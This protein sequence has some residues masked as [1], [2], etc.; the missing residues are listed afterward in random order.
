[1]TPRFNSTYYYSFENSPTPQAVYEEKNHTLKLHLSFANYNAKEFEVNNSLFELRNECD[2]I[3]SL[4]TNLDSLNFT[5][6][7]FN[8][9][10]TLLNPDIETTLISP[11]HDFLMSAHKK[12]VE[13]FLPTASQNDELPKPRITP[14]QNELLF[15]SGFKFDQK[16]NLKML[17]LPEIAQ[18]ILMSNNL[19][20]F[21]NFKYSI[22]KMKYQSPII[23]FNAKVEKRMYLHPKV[24]ILAPVEKKAEIKKS[25][26]NDNACIIC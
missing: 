8:I 22:S 24:E 25:A 12:A 26:K 18:N 15:I 4:K 20:N 9:K 16:C 1:M 13:I 17:L 14:T 3:E 10:N 5:H 11:T 7:V 2:I 21:K 23:E 6:L 19:F